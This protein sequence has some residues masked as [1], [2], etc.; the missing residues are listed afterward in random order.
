MAKADCELRGN[1]A[2]LQAPQTE[3]PNFLDVTTWRLPEDLYARCASAGIP[4]EAESPKTHSSK[5]PT[6]DW[7]P[8]LVNERSEEIRERMLMMP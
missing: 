8:L 3:L 1:N 2:L 7:S 6:D 5:G 4:H